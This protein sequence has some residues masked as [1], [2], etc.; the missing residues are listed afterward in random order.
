MSQG[1]SS[2]RNWSRP[3][4]MGPTSG[5]L[6]ASLNTAHRRV[7]PPSTL[8]SMSR[9]ALPMPRWGRAFWRWELAMLF[10]ITATGR[11]LVLRSSPVRMSASYSG[12]TPKAGSSCSPSGGGVTAMSL[13]ASNEAAVSPFFA[14]PL[15]RPGSLPP[16]A[17]LPAAEQPV[18]ASAAAASPEI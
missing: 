6:S 16:S 10:T 7:M 11:L 17:A 15:S 8:A 3:E 1:M 18:R 12:M 5:M 13:A 2:C 9:S 14:R 4:R